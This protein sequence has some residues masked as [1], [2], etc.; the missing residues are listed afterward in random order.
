MNEITPPKEIPLDHSRLASGML[1][2]E[3]TNE[4]TAMIGPTI[5]F[6]TSRNGS[7]PLFKNSASHQFDGT[8]AARNPAMRKPAVISF[9]NMLQSITNALATAVHLPATCACSCA[10]SS[11]E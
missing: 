2:T 6:S 3:Q 4:S 10:C 11:C 1:P 8:S 7:G 5:A 9:H